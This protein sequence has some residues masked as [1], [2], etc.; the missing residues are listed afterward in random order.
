MKL[1]NQYRIREA[2]EWT[3]PRYMATICPLAGNETGEIKSTQYLDHHFS[4]LYRAAIKSIIDS[5]YP[6]GKTIK[7][8]ELPIHA[9]PI[10]AGIR[11]VL[12]P[13]INRLSPAGTER[14]ARLSGW[15]PQNCSDF[16]LEVVKWENDWDQQYMHETNLS[17][18]RFLKPI[19]SGALKFFYD[20]YAIVKYQNEKR[21][22]IPSSHVQ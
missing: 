20:Q 9:T 15:V 11:Q 18:K 17:A 10:I 13:S 7:R 6:D 14:I 22:W 3:Y 16:C 12:S 19:P 4:K 21:I 8:I 2:V 5:R 1:F